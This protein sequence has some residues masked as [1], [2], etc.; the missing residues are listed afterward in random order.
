MADQS[1]HPEERH[2]QGISKYISLPDLF[3]RNRSGDEQPPSSTKELQ[4][5]GVTWIDVQNPRGSDLDK[6]AR[7][8]GFHAVHM[9]ESLLRG[10]LPQVEKESDYLFMLAYLPIYNAEENKIHSR[11]VGIFLGK[12]YLITIHDEVA[13]E[14]RQWQEMCE[15]DAER[16]Q[17]YFK[18]SSGYLLYS[19]I[20]SILGNATL[21]LQNIL[22][23]LDEVE[24]SV[25]ENNSSDVYRIGS[26][27]HKITKLRRIISSFR[28]VL[29]DLTAAIND[30][31]GESL[32]R[33]YRK[34]MYTNEKLWEL[35]EES[36]ET[37]EIYKDADFTINTERNNKVLTVLTIIFTFSI[38]ATV[39]GAFYGMNVLLPG[40]VL[41]GSW[42]FLGD[43]TTFIVIIVASITPGLLM[44]FS[45]KKQGWM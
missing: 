37:I 5:N 15:R 26:L 30:F 35:I 27:R 39:L 34:N 29:D 12:H 7:D 43:Y 38:P 11:Q 22:Q 14:I 1:H 42:H 25:F 44:Y 40:G 16:R 3:S 6:L 20:A 4:H 33:H 24:D 2:L 31:S 36:R 45:F 23:E 21:L 10:Q 8:Y 13:G 18:H 41:A 32:A 17:H 19:L 9:D 28:S